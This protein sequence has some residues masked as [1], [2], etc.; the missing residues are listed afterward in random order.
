MR[1]LD[2][3]AEH[4]LQTRA[5]RG[6]LRRP[7]AFRRNGASVHRG[8]RSWVS[9]AG[10]DYLGLSMHPAVIAAGR[11]AFEGGAGATASRLVVGT[12]PDVEALEQELAALKKAP[13][14]CLFSSGYHTNLGVIPAL[15]GPEDAVVVDRL[16]HACLFSGIRLSGAT[17]EA[18]D[19]NRVD[20]AHAWLRHHRNE[21]RHVLLVTEGV[22]SMDGDLAP[23]PDWAEL[24][25]RHDA[26]LL[27]DDAHGTGVTGDGRGTVA[28]FGL[29]VRDVPLQ[30]GTLSKAVGTHGGFL[31]ASEAVVALM[32]NRARTLV[33]STGLPP[34]VVASARAALSQIRHDPAPRERLLAH[35]ARL[36]DRLGRPPPPAAILPVLAGDPNRAVAGH[37]ALS[38]LG[39]FVPAMRVPTVPPGTDRLRVSLSALHRTEDVDRLVDGLETLQWRGPEA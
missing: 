9:F 39:L 13:A 31:A 37:Q 1:S 3:F 17:V 14:A 7:V 21:F 8:G 36:A 6:L 22:F 35:G 32:A 4:K 16:A 20:Q 33:Y 34:S 12:D 19:H 24:G 2:A 29:T 30:V 23:L 5:A 26:W 25:R 27:V 15:V 18:V 10:N 38:D 28:R 11:Q